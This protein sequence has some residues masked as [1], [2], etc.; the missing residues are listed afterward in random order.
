MPAARPLEERF[1]E[2]VDRSGGP[3]ACW[4]WN[5]AK[6]R[7]GYGHIRVGPRS[8]GR[9]KNATHVALDLAGRPLERGRI[10]CHRC[11]NP[12]CCN[13]RHLYSGTARQNSIDMIKSGRSCRGQKHWG[14]RLTA[15]QVRKIRASKE[16]SE[17]LAKRVHVSAR[18]IRAIRDG[19]RWS[20]L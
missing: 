1:H 5:G 17:V 2:K 12:P 18:H 14:V 20:Y 16:K 10:V 15:A 4:P 13:P 6:T 7:T 9:F 8:E 11:N 3:D 19:R